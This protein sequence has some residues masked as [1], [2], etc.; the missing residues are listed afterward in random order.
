MNRPAPSPGKFFLNAARCR[1]VDPVSLCESVACPMRTE[2]TARALAEPWGAALEP[3]VAMR[4]A[5][6][7]GVAR[8]GARVEST[9]AR[10]RTASHRALHRLRRSARG[11]CAH[12]LRHLPPRVPA[13][14]LMQDPLLLPELP[15]EARVALR[16]MGRA[17]RARARGAPPV[18]VHAA[19]TSAPDIQP[20]PGVAGRAVPHRRAAAERCVR[21][22]R[23]RRPAAPDPVRADLRGPG[24]LQSPPAGW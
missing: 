1:T 24:Q 22:G 13:R 14:L 7:R 3:A 5:P 19:Q 9:L 15:P 21:R 2:A 6:C 8:L 16:R 18:C 11:L 17:E 20:S 12:L 23:P 4:E 10:S